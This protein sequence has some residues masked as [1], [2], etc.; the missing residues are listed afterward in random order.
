L[1]IPLFEVR[2]RA[3]LRA[4]QARIRDTLLRAD[5]ESFGQLAGQVH[6]AEEEALADLL[7]DVNL[8][9]LTREVQ[10]VREV[11]AALRRILVGRYGLCVEC[12]ERIPRA[13]LEANPTA[14]RCLECQRVHD[15]SPLAAGTPKL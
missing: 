6:D 12:A 3:R 4:L 1:D 9:E 10:E 14:A 5:A 15:Q 13:R 2:L 8:A 11:D 7:V